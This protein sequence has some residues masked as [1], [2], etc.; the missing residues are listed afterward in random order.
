[1]VLDVAV[2]QDTGDKLFLISQSYMPAQQSH[3]LKNPQNSTLSP[4]YS[5][6]EIGSGNVV[7][8]EWT[9]DNNSLMEFGY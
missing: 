4:W 6:E 9:F 5:V 1:M 8:P 2:N 7:T 3:I